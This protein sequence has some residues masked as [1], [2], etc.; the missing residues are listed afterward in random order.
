MRIFREWIQ[1]FRGT[2]LPGRRDADLEH[3]LRSHM[4][5]VADDARRRGLDPDDIRIA[6]GAARSSVVALVMKQGL[7]LTIIGVVVGLA[8]ALG[9]NR[10]IASVLFG[11][12]PTDPTTLAAVIKTITL[13]LRTD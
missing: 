10:L 13:V 9:L 12:Q 6:L 4:E 3:E 7:Q 2:L 1:R 8:G 11:V 5:M